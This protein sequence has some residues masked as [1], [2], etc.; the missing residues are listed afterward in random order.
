MADGMTPS[1]LQEKIL[2]DGLTNLSHG[3][4]LLAELVRDLIIEQRKTNLFLEK[5]LQPPPEVVPYVPQV[6]RVTTAASNLDPE[7]SGKP[8]KPQLPGRK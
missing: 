4:G 8:A 1:T 5:R 2:A 6:G 3:L 7:K